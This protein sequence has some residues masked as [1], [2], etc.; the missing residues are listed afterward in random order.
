MTNLC[1]VCFAWSHNLQ[2]ILVQK[3]IKCKLMAA[4]DVQR[5]RACER[6]KSMIS[7]WK[8]TDRCTQPQ[9]SC[10][11]QIIAFSF[12]H[13]FIRGLVNDWSMT[14]LFSPR[15]QPVR[16]QRT[17]LHVFIKVVRPSVCFQHVCRLMSIAISMFGQFCIS[18]LGIAYQTAQVPC[19]WFSEQ[20]Q[21]A[22]DP[23]CNVLSSWREWG[24]KWSPLLPQKRE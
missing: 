11:T 8:R 21:T 2:E 20:E 4:C 9:S 16:R 10:H 13:S 1:S 7:P 23:T 6:S 24:A 15:W 5:L 19:L 12:I 17:S 22:G 14:S 18:M 3:L